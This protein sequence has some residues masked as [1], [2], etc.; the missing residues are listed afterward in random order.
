LGSLRRCAGFFGDERLRHRRLRDKTRSGRTIETDRVDQH[1]LLDRYQSVAD[2]EHV[3]GGVA[4]R[5][6]VKNGGT[7]GKA[8]QMTRATKLNVLRNKLTSLAAILPLSCVTGPA[9]ELML[10]AGESRVHLSTGC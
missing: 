8:V 6:R 1:E 9:H 3:S 5:E 2:R 4:D 7:L 10:L